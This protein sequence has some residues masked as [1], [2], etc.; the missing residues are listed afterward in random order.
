[1]NAAYG[2]RGP[3]MLPPSPYAPMGAR[4]MYQAA[5]NGQRLPGTYPANGLYPSMP[6]AGYGPG[7]MYAPVQQ[8]GY[9][10]NLPGMGPQG[11]V[12]PGMYGPTVYPAV[13]QAQQP[14]ATGMIPV[15]YF[16]PAGPGGMTPAAGQGFA[17]GQLTP[18]AQARGQMLDMLQNSLYPSQR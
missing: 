18:E 2:F 8:A 11:F 1:M 14:G 3:G 16:T 15:A 4:G 7:G 6:P 5:M 9:S 17:G 12:P 13:A 10:P